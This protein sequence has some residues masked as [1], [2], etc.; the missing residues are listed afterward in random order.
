MSARIISKELSFLYISKLNLSVPVPVER[1]HSRIRA[2]PLVAF[3]FPF[4]LPSQRLPL[5]H[6]Q[7]I[8]SFYT[9][10]LQR[11][12]FPFNRRTSNV[13]Q[14]PTIL[15]LTPSSPSSTFHNACSAAVSFPSI[16][17]LLD[18]GFTFS[19]PNNTNP[20]WALWT[21]HSPF[22]FP[23]RRHKAIFIVS[24]FP[25]SRSILVRS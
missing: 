9:F 24:S 21:L 1:L 17:L 4:Y 11:L 7:F 13:A 20:L 14:K 25:L 6:R 18:I 16:L 15:P 12:A 10:F 3:S 19:E 5:W 2:S 8:P 22:P 23:F